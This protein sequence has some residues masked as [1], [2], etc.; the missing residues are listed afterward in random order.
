MEDKAAKLWF[1][2]TG[3]ILNVLLRTWLEVLNEK[4][5]PGVGIKVREI[6][7]NHLTWDI[8]SKK[9]HSVKGVLFLYCRNSKCSCGHTGLVSFV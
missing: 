4:R 7:P 5:I 6:F 8:A 9:K 3:A 1:T 2:W